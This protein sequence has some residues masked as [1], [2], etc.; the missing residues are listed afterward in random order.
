LT[1][2]L[3]LVVFLALLLGLPGPPTLVGSQADTDRQKA[4][5]L[6][7]LML[8]A[9]GGKEHL[10]AVNNVQMSVREKY[11]WWLKRMEIN[12]EGLFVFPDKSWEWDDQRGTVFGMSIH[13]H[14]F[15]SNKHVSYVDTGKGARVVP[16][17]Q[18]SKRNLI[19]LQLHLLAQTKWVKPI[20][21]SFRTG[22]LGDREVDF[23]ETT[24]L[25][26][27]S[28]EQKVEFALD[29]KSHLPLRVI[30]YWVINGKELSG[31]V[32]LS[33]YMD[34]DGIKMPAKV[35]VVRSKYQ[36]NV[37]YD[38]RIFEQPPSLTAGIEAWKKRTN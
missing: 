20:P 25:N 5:R 2:N 6:W 13:L 26:F 30:Y 28:N 4:E 9:K 14:N 23:V 7:E 17:L 19:Q 12:Y 29:R 8:E 37:E 34:V 3:V 27:P 38:V 33:D 1:R 22:K 36:L 24:V 10:L 35:G 31:G 32:S 16:I 21:Q 11:W 18:P 15:E